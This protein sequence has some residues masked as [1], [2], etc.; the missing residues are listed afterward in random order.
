[1]NTSTVQ[2]GSDFPMSSPSGSR[3]LRVDAL[4]GLFLVLMTVTHVPTRFSDWL[5]QPFGFVSAAEGF[6]CLSAYLA[7]RVYLRRYEKAGFAAMRGALVARAV[8][9]YR[10]HLGLFLFGI[11]VALALAAQLGQD[12]VTGLFSYYIGQ[13]LTAFFGA[14]ALVYQAP[15][16]DILPMYVLFLL[17]TPWVLA[18]AHRHGWAFM[19]MLSLSLWLAAQFGLRQ[20]AYDAVA[21]LSGLRIPVDAIGLFNPLAWQFLWMIGLWLGTR[22]PLAETR[23]REPQWLWP[24]ALAA[25]LAMLLFRHATGQVPFGPD[26]WVNALFDKWNLGPVRMLN[27]LVLAAIIQGYARGVADRLPLS[28]LAQLGQASLWVFT[29]HIVICFAVLTLFGTASPERPW[30]LDL[31]LMLASF[32]ILQGVAVLYQRH[33]ARLRAAR[34]APML[35]SEPPFAPAPAAPPLAGNSR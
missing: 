26:N 3:N 4:R 24:A 18:A 5:G 8:K 30:A 2:P 21:S 20:A 14:I 17:A 35:R 22:G 27:V 32:A 33:E 7:G 13:P 29:A 12:A 16:L 9:V 11:G 25:G 34:A 31:A 19:L 10:V 1:M 6:V 28:T 23:A 15:L